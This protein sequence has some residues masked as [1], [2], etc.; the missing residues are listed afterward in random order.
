[1]HRGLCGGFDTLNANPG[2]SADIELLISESLNLH[3]CVGDGIRSVEVG[4]CKRK[5][6]K[7]AR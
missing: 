4:D 5:R 3:V 6:E 1:M 7:E 2:A